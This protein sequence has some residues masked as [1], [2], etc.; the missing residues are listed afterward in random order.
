VPTSKTAKEALLNALR[1]HLEHPGEKDIDGNV[2]AIQPSQSYWINTEWIGDSIGK[3]GLPQVSVFTF[4]GPSIDTKKEGE[5]YYFL[6]AQMDVFGSGNDQRE[7][8]T[9]QVKDALLQQDYRA[10]LADSGLKIDGLRASNDVIEDER[11]PQKI[12]RKTITFSGI[13]SSSGA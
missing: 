5:R 3:Y 1:Q 7:D 6:T 11:L 9:H 2:L 10:S 4:E 8:L 13:Y 12:Y